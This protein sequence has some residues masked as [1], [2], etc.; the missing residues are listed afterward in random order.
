MEEVLAA[1]ENLQVAQK[2]AVVK[3]TVKSFNAQERAELSSFLDGFNQSNITVNY[4]D[5]GS[6]QNTGDSTA[7]PS[8]F[9]KNEILVSGSFV[10]INTGFSL[11]IQNSE[12]IQIQQPTDKDYQAFTILVAI[13]Q[14][15]K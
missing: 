15:V 1:L 7:N 10:S 3:E 6:K 14:I 5:F 4:P 9:T 13:L 2:L 12:F 11:N 8:Q